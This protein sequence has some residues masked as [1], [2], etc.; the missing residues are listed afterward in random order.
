[1][2]SQAIIKE[3]I[4]IKESFY[5]WCVKNNVKDALE[6]WDYELNNTSPNN[7][8]SWDKTKLAA[9]HKKILPEEEL[10]YQ[11]WKD[12]FKRDYAIS[13]G[14]FYLEIPYYTDDKLETYKKLIDNKINEIKLHSIA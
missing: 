8:S 11:K 14:Y 1:M 10:E 9:K 2:Q 13:H 5:D 12:E 4:F 6:R 3:G 7:V